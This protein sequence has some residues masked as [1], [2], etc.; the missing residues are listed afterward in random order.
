MAA[1]DNCGGQVMIYDPGQ[2]GRTVP[3]EEVGDR[4]GVPR[5]DEIPDEPDEEGE[6]WK[7]VKRETETVEVSGVTIER[8]TAVNMRRPN[9]TIV[10]LEFNGS[11]EED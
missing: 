5:L 3:V 9:G 2:P 7:E 4:L 1:E 8:M 6:V 10:R 11:G